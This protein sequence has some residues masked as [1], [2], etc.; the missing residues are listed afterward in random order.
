MDGAP[1][2]ATAGGAAGSGKPSKA[3]KKA[4]LREES[5]D[6][7]KDNKLGRGMRAARMAAVKASRK[8]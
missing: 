6:K 5:K 1:A 4:M 2:K 3:A 7:D 8:G